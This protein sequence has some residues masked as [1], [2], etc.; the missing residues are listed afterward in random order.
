MSRLNYHF[1]IINFIKTGL[2][3]KIKNIKMK[4]RENWWKGGA[5]K[6]IIAKGPL[7]T[8]SFFIHPCK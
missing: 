3:T 7:E 6:I 2:K 1:F 5:P 8:Y 4:L